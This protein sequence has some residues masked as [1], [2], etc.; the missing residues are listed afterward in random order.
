[1]YRPYAAD[2]VSRVLEML[3]SCCTYDCTKTLKSGDTKFYKAAHEPATQW[4]RQHPQNTSYCAP[5]DPS[6]TNYIHIFA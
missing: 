2:R 5:S 1:M 6:L 3:V 4:Q